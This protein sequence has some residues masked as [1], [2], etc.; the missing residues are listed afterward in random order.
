MTMTTRTTTVLLQILWDTVHLPW[1]QTPLPKWRCRL[2]RLKIK[3]WTHLYAAMK[4]ILT[5]PAQ[6]MTRSVV[7]VNLCGCVFNVYP[8]LSYL[9]QCGKPSVSSFCSLTFALTGYFQLGGFSFIK[10]QSSDIS[11][12]N[13]FWEHAPLKQMV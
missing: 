6:F 8:L 12:K 4:L 7:N 9:E 11:S 2:T 10:M 1:L 5:M 3:I 13:S